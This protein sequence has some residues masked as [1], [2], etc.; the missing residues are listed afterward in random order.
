MTS[1]S[2]KHT[3]PLKRKDWHHSKS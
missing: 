1:L 3:R 2:S